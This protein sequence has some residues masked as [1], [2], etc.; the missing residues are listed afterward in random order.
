MAIIKWNEN[1]SI[2][3]ETIDKQ[4]QELVNLLNSLEEATCQS[5]NTQTAEQTLDKLLN[6]T[7]EHF[8][9]EE[10]WMRQNG[11][12]DMRR[13]IEEHRELADKV[14][15]LKEELKTADKT[16]NKEIVALIADWILDHILGSDLKAVKKVSNG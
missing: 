1:L 15:G 13:H 4:H 14:L 12:T 10:R 11:Y 8:A 7:I 5:L 6:Y 3:D 2:G 9:A 16:I